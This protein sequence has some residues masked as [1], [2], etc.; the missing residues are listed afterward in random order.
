MSQFAGMTDAQLQR[1]RAQLAID[2]TPQAKIQLEQ[3]IAELR[4]RS[5]QA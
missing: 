3:V 5:T 1:L 2:R 4:R